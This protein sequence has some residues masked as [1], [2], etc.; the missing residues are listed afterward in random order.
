MMKRTFCIALVVTACGKGGHDSGKSATIDLFGPKPVPPGELAKV[1][2]GMTQAQVKALFPSIHPTPNSSGSP[3][4][5]ID[6]GYANAEYRIVFYSDKDAVAEVTVEVPPDLAKQLDKAWG[7]PTDTGPMGKKWV[8]DQDGFE[9]HA[10]DMGRKTW[11]G[12]RPFVPL[13]ADYFG[14]K[15]GAFDVLAKVKPGMSRD[16]IAKASPGFEKAGA[17][18]GN[19]SFVPYDGKPKDVHIR[20]DYDQ[21]DKARDYVVELPEKG[22]EML[23]KAWGPHPGKARGLGSPMNCWDLGDG[24]RLELDGTRLTYTTPA[25]SVCE[26]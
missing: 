19:G 16:E 4:F 3:S 9:V 7:P 24:T 12:Y 11:V 22:A 18:K 25:N 26:I 2:V 8:D 21:D 6:S 15:P 20:I 17:P 10:T 14:S 5:T 23:T 13:N 1:K